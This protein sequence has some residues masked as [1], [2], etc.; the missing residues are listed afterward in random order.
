MARHRRGLRASNID[1]SAFGFTIVQWSADGKGWR[2]TTLGYLK[3]ISSIIQYK[4]FITG[5]AEC[6]EQCNHWFDS[7]LKSLTGATCWQNIQNRT[8]SGKLFSL[9]FPLSF[10]LSIWLF[11]FGKDYTDTICPNASGSRVGWNDLNF[12]SSEAHCETSHKA[13]PRVQLTCVYI[14]LWGGLCLKDKYI[15]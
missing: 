6:H 12:G 4:S 3:A 5:F 2:F 10:W 7:L 14:F 13:R 8:L 1:W 11:L 9:E 15:S